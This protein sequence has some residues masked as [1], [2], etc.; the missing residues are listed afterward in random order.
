MLVLPQKF[1]LILLL[2]STRKVSIHKPFEVLR[3]VGWRKLKGCGCARRWSEGLSEAQGLPSLSAGLYFCLWG[4][5]CRLWPV[6]PGCLQELCGFVC[7][8]VASLENATVVSPTYTAA[9]WSI[10]F[11]SSPS[12]F[13]S[14]VLLYFSFQQD[15][16]HW[17]RKKN[18]VIYH[19]IMYN[20][21]S[22]PCSFLASPFIIDIMCTLMITELE[23]L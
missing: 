16:D 1:Q 2:F 9:L 18:E 5:G 8:T 20:F 7:W 11:L 10:T 15:E 6:E 12:F 19:N 21:K 17:V 4:P 23:L 13:P 3:T 22:K 14:P